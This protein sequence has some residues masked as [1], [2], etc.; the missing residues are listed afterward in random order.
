MP[1]LSKREIAYY[2]I[3]RSVFDYSEF[4]YGE[5]LDL[6]KLFGPRR[7]VR[8][9]LKRMASRGFVERVKPLVYRLKPLDEALEVTLLEYIAKRL[10]KYLRS[11][12]LDVEVTID[13][14]SKTIAVRGCGEELSKIL[15]RFEWRSL[16]IVCEDVG[17]LKKPR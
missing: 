3:L 7:L 10:E 16:R 17:D 14:E 12:H 15:T 5:A 4:N 11:K 1:W 9:M 6:L 2:L 8:K 13:R